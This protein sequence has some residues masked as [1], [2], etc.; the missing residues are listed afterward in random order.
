MMDCFELFYELI[1]VCALLIM[2]FVFAVIAGNYE[3]RIIGNH[4]SIGI[5]VVLTCDK[6]DHI[7]VISWLRNDVILVPGQL[8][9]G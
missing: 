9:S 6:R 3:P 7:N 4:A 5:P 1:I 8:E 2:Y